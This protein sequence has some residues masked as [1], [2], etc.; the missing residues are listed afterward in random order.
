MLVYDPQHQLTKGSHGLELLEVHEGNIMRVRAPLY[1]EFKVILP[2]LLELD[3]LEV[4]NIAGNKKIQ[5]TIKHSKD[6]SEGSLSHPEATI[7]YQWEFPT[8][9]GQRFSAVTVNVK[10]L[11]DFCDFLTSTG[12]EIFYIHDF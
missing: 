4:L 1:H 10:G 5:I 8:L 12:I 9:P 11:K 2:S 6:L 7:G 3:Q